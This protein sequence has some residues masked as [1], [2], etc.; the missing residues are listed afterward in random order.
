MEK[1]MCN[2]CATNKSKSEIIKCSN[3]DFECCKSC[4]KEYIKSKFKDIVN[5]MNC[6]ITFTRHTLVSYLGITYINKEFKQIQDKIRIDRQLSLL[7]TFQD[8]AKTEKLLEK[9]IK[10]M[11]ELR[12][13]LL[14]KQ[15]VIR[16]LEYITKFPTDKKNYIRQCSIAECKGFLNS[17]YKCDL[18]DNVTCKDCL[19]PVKT[20]HI[21]DPDTKKTA[22]LLKKDTKYCPKCNNGIYKI[23]GCDQIFCTI[24]CTAFSWKTGIIE[25]GRIHNPHY[26]EM[27]RKQATNGEI[28]REEDLIERQNC[29]VINNNILRQCN[30]LY[31]N[32]NEIIKKISYFMMEYIR[33]YYHV[34]SINETFESI[35]IKINNN[36]ERKNIDYLKNEINKEEYEKS[37]S[38]YGKK[39]ELS[40]EK[41]MIINTLKNSIN[42]I[43][44]KFY[45][46]V[47]NK[48]L[49]ANH[50]VLIT[51]E[52]N[53]IETKNKLEL[54]I[55]YC[56]EE[57]LKLIKL[58][59]SKSKLDILNYPKFHIELSKT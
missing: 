1:V 7:P 26:Y 12:K 14:E 5:C 55:N 10:E 36:I 43:I 38:I 57:D 31:K 29:D 46:E 25:T 8:K 13:I 34:N 18:C 30:H 19:E 23:D 56:I 16:D 17:N 35:L 33:Y 22:E 42:D 45:K 51:Y 24:C 40:N 49:D 47:C 59:S 54:F 39:A 41:L 6:K 44:M 53:M 2:I 28:P 4:L 48:L 27:L 21:C 11:I 3:C 20:D 9:E 58:Y 32:K 37:I 50:I 52:N 15:S